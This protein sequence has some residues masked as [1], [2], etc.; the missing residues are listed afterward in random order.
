MA[1]DEMSKRKR[2]LTENIEQGFIDLRDNNERCS[3][4]MMEAQKSLEK[5]WGQRLNWQ[6]KNSDVL[7]QLW[8]GKGWKEETKRG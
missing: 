3:I 5:Q 1:A 7:T 6:G 2:K 4:H 8:Q